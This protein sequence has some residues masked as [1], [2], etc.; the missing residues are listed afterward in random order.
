MAADSAPAKDPASGTEKKTGDKK[1]T[2]PAK[3][4]RLRGEIT[5][6]NTAAGTVSV[7]NTSEEKSFMTQD[8]AKDSL[9]VLKVGDQVRVTYSEKDG[10]L[11][12]TSLKRLKPKNT[13]SGN[14]RKKSTVNP[15]PQSSGVLGSRLASATESLGLG[16]M[17]H[18]RAEDICQQNT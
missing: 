15:T 6:F 9:E 4:Q 5:A 8:A 12:A 14:K 2:K 13:S 18:A 3:P 1:K 10:K 16:L 7:K 17:I 11:V